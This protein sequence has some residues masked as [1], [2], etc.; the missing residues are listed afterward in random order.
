M[1]GWVHSVSTEFLGRN[2]PDRAAPVPM[3]AQEGRNSHP[4]VHVKLLV[5]CTSATCYTEVSEYAQAAPP[6]AES[7]LR[8]KKIV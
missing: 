4:G 7:M 1:P 5:C 2:I 8:H 3:L 6:A